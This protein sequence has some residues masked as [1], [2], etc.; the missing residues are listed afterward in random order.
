MHIKYL[1]SRSKQLSVSLCC[2][3]DTNL[4]KSEK[5]VKSTEWTKLEHL[6]VK[7]TL[8]ILITYSWVPNFHPFCSMTS[9][10]Q[11]IMLLKIRN[12]GNVP[13]YLT[14]ILKMLTVKSTSYIRLNYSRARFSLQ[15]AILEIQGCCKSRKTKM[16]WMTSYWLW[17]LNSQK[18]LIYTF[19]LRPAIF[20]TQGCWRSEMHWMTSKLPRILDRKKYFAFTK[21]SLPSPSPFSPRPKFWSISPMANIFQCTRLSKSEMHRMTSC[22]LWNLNSQKCLIYTHIY[23]ER[24]QDP[25]KCISRLELYREPVYS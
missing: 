12:F 21:Y 1:H 20:K 15:P 2:F 16:Y 9:R 24:K 22:W 14:L 6:T 4:L 10:F 13:N 18:Y 3:Q 5:S 11:D 19:A 7:N 17:T 23:F 8:H 25:W